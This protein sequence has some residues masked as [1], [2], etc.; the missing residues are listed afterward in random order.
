MLVMSKDTHSIVPLEPLGD[1]TGMKCNLGKD[2]MCELKELFNTM[3]LRQK[4]FE[5]RQ[6][7]NEI[8]IANADKNIA[9]IQKDLAETK[10][11]FRLVSERVNVNTEQLIDIKEDI[12]PIVDGIGELR[13][14]L[15]PW[16]WTIKKFK[17]IATTVLAGWVLFMDGVEHLM[18]FLKGHH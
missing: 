16:I 17:W 11:E 10:S 6:A 13:I 9:L 15:K 8:S 2:K 4:S 3:E 12:R 7:K 1:S 18:N 14:V 5:A